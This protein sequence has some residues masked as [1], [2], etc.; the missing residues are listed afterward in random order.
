MMESPREYTD[1]GLE[2]LMGWQIVSTKELKREK[3][4]AWAQGYVARIQ[5]NMAENLAE[6]KGREIPTASAQNPY[7]EDDE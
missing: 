4:K 6:I 3:A 7:L 5:E 2:A 1:A